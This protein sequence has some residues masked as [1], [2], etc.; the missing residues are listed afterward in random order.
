MDIFKE[1]KSRV[2]ILKI[3]YILGIKLDK[4]Y[5]ALCPF[6][7]EKTPSFS[8]LPSKNIFCCFGCGKKGDSIT[9]VSELLNISQLEAAKYI[10]ENLGLGIE[11]NIKKYQTKEEKKK[12]DAL[13]NEYEQKRKKREYFKEKENHTFQILCDYFHLLKHYKELKDI[14]N[15]DYIES[16]QQIDKIE[17]YID[18]FINGTEKDKKWFLNTNGKVVKEYARKLGRE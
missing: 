2:N 5:K 9:L 13:L 8:V 15:E 12:Y 6:H 1:V 16:L 3:C 4:N 10:N 17:Y 7:K 14:N 11:T 18:F